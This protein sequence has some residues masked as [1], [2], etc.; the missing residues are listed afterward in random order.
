M[1][2]IS[3]LIDVPVGFFSEKNQHIITKIS[4]IYLGSNMKI[5][6]DSL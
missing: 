3:L 2:E 1:K 4:P 5:V 6:C